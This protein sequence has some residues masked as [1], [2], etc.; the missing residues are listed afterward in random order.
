[1][2]FR[3]EPFYLLRAWSG[4][5]PRVPNWSTYPGLALCEMLLYAEI[6]P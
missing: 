5:S 6:I 4:T 3:K 1:M 2:K